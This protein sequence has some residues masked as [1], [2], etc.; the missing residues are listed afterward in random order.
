M[1]IGEKAKQI[2]AA[3]APTLGT[4]IGGPFGAIAGTVLANALGTKND[5]AAVEQA[6]ASGNPEVLLRLKDAENSF[7]LQLEQLGV[8]REQLAYQDTAN[9]RDREVKLGDWTPRILAGVIVFGYFA[10]QWFILSHIVPSE[11]R[12]IVMRSL[13]VL[14]T[15][16]GL[17]LGYYFGSSSGSRLKDAALARK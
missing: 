4:A 3:V 8:Q 14:D 5:T 16:L 13:G 6:I 11:Q 1:N 15:A 17:V 7:K 2:I 9:A 10:V 12:E